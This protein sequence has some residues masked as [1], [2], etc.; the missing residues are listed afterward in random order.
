MFPLDPAPQQAVSPA[1]S[2]TREARDPVER[3][4]LDARYRVLAEV[5]WG[6]EGIGD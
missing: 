1:G 3:A 5:P 2:Q 6:F 4:D